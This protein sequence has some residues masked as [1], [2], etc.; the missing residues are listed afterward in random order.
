[1]TLK[2]FHGKFGAVLLKRWNYD[3]G[4]IRVVIYHDHINRAD[5]I[6]KELLVVNFA[7]MLVNSMGYTLGRQEEIELENAESTRL[8]KI[9]P[10]LIE[11]FSDKVKKQM[12]ATLD[13]L[14]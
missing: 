10:E 12:K 4:A 9:T 3:K 7:N 2:E 11:E 14:S 1:K 6:S 8:L 13:I 5:V